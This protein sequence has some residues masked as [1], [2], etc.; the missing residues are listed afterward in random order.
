[1]RHAKTLD[2]KLVENKEINRVSRTDNELQYYMQNFRN[3]QPLSRPEVV[4]LVKRYREGDLKARD[5]LVYHN[6]RLVAAIALHYLNSGLPLSDRIQLGV[7][8]LMTSLKT[9]D[10]EKSSLPTWATRHI[11]NEIN[12]GIEYESTTRPFRISSPMTSRVRLVA[13]AI[14]TF[15]ATFARCPSEEEIYLWIKTLVGTADETN[16][17]RDISRKDVIVCCRDLI[18]RGQWRSLDAPILSPQRKTERKIDGYFG[19]FV[20]DPHHDPV[21]ELEEDV[22]TNERVAL[23]DNLVT[24]N[25]IAD[26]DLELLRLRADGETLSEIGKKCNRSRERIRQREELLLKK[27]GRTLDI[28]PQAQLSAKTMPTTRGAIAAPQPQQAVGSLFEGKRMTLPKRQN[29]FYRANRLGNR[30]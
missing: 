3:C 19:D 14:K 17:A 20:V 2:P 23:L 11:Q 12:R 10:P 18:D 28:S 15:Q 27:I 5:T 9:F 26:Q 21:A 29:I 16:V 24:K 4:Q 8:G 25:V 7:I 1:M 13:L 22:E 6:M 30:K